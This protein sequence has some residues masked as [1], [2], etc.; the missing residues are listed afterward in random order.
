M[1]GLEYI[2]KY[3]DDF[4]K[5]ESV[6]MEHSS[7][8]SFCLPYVDKRSNMLDICCGN[9]RDSIFF[10]NNMV[11]VCAF[12]LHPIGNINFG[13]TIY[14]LEN[15]TH[16]FVYDD[17]SFGSIYCRFVLHCMPEDIE[18]YI[19]I[20]SSHVLKDNGLLFIEAR[21]DKGVIPDN[22]Q[23]HYRRLINKDS[24]IQKI[25]NLNFE[26][27]EIDERDGLSIYNNE[28]PVL[29]R[30]VAKKKGII[31]I[32]SKLTWDEWYIPNRHLN[33][34]SSTHLLLSTKKVLDSH[35]ISFWVIFGTL[36]GI[37]RDKKFI[38]YD[39]DID[40]GIKYND[41]TKVLDIIN[42]GYFAIYG[43]SFIR[44]ASPHLYSLRYK[45]DY[46]DLDFFAKIKNL[47]R[48]AIHIIIPS[49]IE[50][51]PTE[52]T[53]LDHTF[54]TVNDIEKYL[55]YVYGNWKIRIRNKH[56]RK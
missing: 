26:I 36:L 20:N 41:I 33:E 8:A 25:E 45:D 5:K 11:N 7:F 3:W 42:E 47:Y 44:D 49:Q 13:Y 12:D 51:P 14:N 21:S 28:D 56:A 15:K 27:I 22:L 37:Y 1:S 2:S 4:Y 30:I 19:L 35:N 52:I 23:N 34:E 24:L 17:N 53:F 29:I 46:I 10:A 18:D 6:T 43:L 31:E 48:C 40:L 39:T 9:G 32:N 38:E 50:H 55:R 16:G 54:N